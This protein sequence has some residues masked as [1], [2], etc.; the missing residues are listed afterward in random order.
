[1]NAPRRK[2]DMVPIREHIEELLRSH[3]E[4]LESLIVAQ[5]RRFEDLRIADQR[6]L[7][8]AFAAADK[9]VQTAFASADKAVH[10][11]LEGQKERS[12]Q[13]DAGM[14]R[15]L[16]LLNE[17]RTGVA[18]NEQ[19]AGAVR[20]I[21][22]LKERIDKAEAREQGRS[23]GLKDYIGWIIAALTVASSVIGFALLLRK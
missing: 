6:A 16:N 22:D 18:T 7:E 21:D 3:R 19:M 23:G 2:D 15:R 13:Q 4:H 10:V 17:L 20:R 8:A 1:M 12:Q 14:E 5:G 9:A 11:A